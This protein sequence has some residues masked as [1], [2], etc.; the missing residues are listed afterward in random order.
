MSSAAAAESFRVCAAVLNEDIMADKKGILAV[1]FGTSYERARKESIDAVE[2][3]WRSVFPD[4]E[5]RRAFTSPRIIRRLAAQ[6]LSV[7]DVVQA[8]KCM[9][10]EGFTHVW[11]QPTLLIPGEEYERLCEAVAPFACDFALLK[12][13]EPLLCQEEDYDNAVRI[14]MDKY[15]VRKGEACVLMGHGTPHDANYIYKRIG[16]KLETKSEGRYSLATVEGDPAIEEVADRLPRDVRKVTLVPFMLVAG[17]HAMND[18]AG[19]EP[20]S[21]RSALEARGYE[22]ECVIRGMG[23]YPEIRALYDAKLRKLRSDDEE[24]AL[25]ET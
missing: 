8:L 25:E 20:G 10:A 17:D 7:P 2:E 4:C 11:V 3:Q 14:M 13:G 23:A 16:E 12:I 1:S 24:K 6:G 21:F 9:K 19:Q 18:M 22:V 5:L 15:P